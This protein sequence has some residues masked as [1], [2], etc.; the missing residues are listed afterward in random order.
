MDPR[1]WV[2]WSETSFR[3]MA[4]AWLS[5][6]AAVLMK[7][8]NADVVD[9]LMT[10]LMESFLRDKASTALALVMRSTWT[11]CR[12]VVRSSAVGIWAGAPPMGGAGGVGGRAKGATGAAGA[13]V[14][15]AA[16]GGGVGG[17][18][19]SHL[20]HGFN[21]SQKLVCITCQLLVR[22]SQL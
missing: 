4:V 5:L 1:P 6:D 20:I 18:D 9:W 2:S 10:L 8:L 11:M 12:M 21:R 3:A 7:C 13:V 15:R 17:R 16:G 14:G 19:T 22:L